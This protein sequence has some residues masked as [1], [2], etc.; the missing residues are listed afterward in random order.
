VVNEQEKRSK[1]M[2]KR[3]VRSLS[4]A[5]C[6]KRILETAEETAKA[7]KGGWLFTGIWPS[8]TQRVM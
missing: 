5:H 4:K 2:K 1:P 8:S 7:I 6:H 3:L